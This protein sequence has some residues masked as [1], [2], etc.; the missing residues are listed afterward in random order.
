MKLIYDIVSYATLN[1]YVDDLSTI[2][3]T[4]EGKKVIMISWDMAGAVSR[5]AEW[6]TLAS[7]LYTI[8]DED[9]KE[10]YSWN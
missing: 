4:R 10:I 3:V 8:G 2:Q 6:S 5:L 1:G 9:C 7:F